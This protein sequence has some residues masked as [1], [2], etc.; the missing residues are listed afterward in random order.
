VPLPWPILA[1]LLPTVLLAA[2][3]DART[4]RVP[5]WLTY[6]AAILGPSLHFAVGGAETAGMSVVA[7]LVLLV[8]AAL[9]MNG[10]DAKLLGAVG[11]YA[12]WPGALWAA[13]GAFAVALVWAVA[14]AIARRRA[15]L[16]PVLAVFLSILAGR[17]INPSAPDSP[18]VPFAACAAVGVIGWLAAAAIRYNV[19]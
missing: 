6:P 13:F 18:R 7:L 4:E 17:P 11:A 5:N 15:V 2:F 10:G 14:L 1:V 8:P 3:F 19:R 16:G 9:V 12:G